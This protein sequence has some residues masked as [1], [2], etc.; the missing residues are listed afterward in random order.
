MTNETEKRS[1]WK[2][3]TF[4]TGVVST[5]LLFAGFAYFLFCL[6]V[7]QGE[8]AYFNKW[9][10]LVHATPNEV[11]DTLAGFAGSL[12]FIWLV[13][14]VLL[15]S[16]EL[17]EQ[18][19]ATKDMADAMDVQAKI[20]LDEQRQRS[21]AESDSIV[22]AWLE[23]LYSEILRGGARNLSWKLR[24]PSDWKPHM[25]G[26]SLGV[27]SGLSENP[28]IDMNFLRLCTNL[29]R[30]IAR[31]KGAKEALEIREKPMSSEPLK[32]VISI[33]TKI[34]AETSSCSKVMRSRLRRIKIGTT[35][36]CLLEVLNDRDLWARS[37]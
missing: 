27:F 13:V 36:H 9:S 16:K 1:I 29:T 35:H 33:L 25:G 28:D 26:D 10:Y 6:P 20:F 4:L 17:R 21:E 7:I 22:S 32:K 18:K 11:G 34:D 31:L 3:P 15:Q 19:K 2:E 12:A 8:E 5:V 23:E 30:D 24:K 14:A 37:T